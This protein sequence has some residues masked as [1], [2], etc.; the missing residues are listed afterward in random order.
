MTEQNQY[1]PLRTTFDKHKYNEGRI[2]DFENKNIIK[3][4]AA[5]YGVTPEHVEREMRIAIREAMKST[6]S[7]TRELWEQLAPNGTEPN[8][9]TFLNFCASSCGKQ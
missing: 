1:N 9:D 7:H 2:G 4:I 5:Q 8:I 3:K 6:D